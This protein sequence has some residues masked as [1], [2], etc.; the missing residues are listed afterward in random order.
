MSPQ[1]P[2]VTELPRWA[3]ELIAGARVAHL[4]LLDGDGRP[5]VLPVTFAAIGGDL[6]SAVD[7]KPK[8]T[9]G[10]DLARVRWLRRR[11]DAAL[12]VDRYSD[13]WERLAWVQALGTVDV[14]DVAEPAALAALQAKYQQYRERP[15][16]G[17]FLRLAPERFLFWAADAL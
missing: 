3:R 17:P 9:A 14:L 4:G 8:A 11:P 10:R 12:T 1:S 5:R 13:D 7:H 2:S 16:A 6:W 15:P